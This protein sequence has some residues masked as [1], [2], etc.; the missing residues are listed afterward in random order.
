MVNT[1]K[2]DLE[3]SLHNP[4]GLRTNCGYCAISRGLLIQQ[5]ISIDADQ[6][7]VQTL[8]RLRLPT[9]EPTDPIPRTLFFPDAHS[10]LK[11]RASHG[12]VDQGVLSGDMYTIWSVAT[13]CGLKWESG[14]K[15]LLFQF[16]ANYSIVDYSQVFE[17]VANLRYESAIESGK[18]P[19]S[20]ERLHSYISHELVGEGI[21]GC[22]SDEHF[23][24]VTISRSG[25]MEFF[26]PQEG[27][28]YNGR[29]LRYKA[30]RIDL[31]MRV[32]ADI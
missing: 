22:V 23:L 6:L 15:D 2:G 31:F 12:A 9:D 26:D 29:D 18:N 10:D 21:I 24:N 27:K 20:L 14:N 13:G 19:G 1:K 17:R 3:P 8:K 4:S 32:P 25:H 5:G 28:R 7:Y 16:V 11:V 30:M